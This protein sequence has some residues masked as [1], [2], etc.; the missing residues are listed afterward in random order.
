M[1]TLTVIALGIIIGLAA[2]LQKG[3]RS[4]ECLYHHRK[5]LLPISLIIICYGTFNFGANVFPLD[6]LFHLMQKQGAIRAF[7]DLE[8]NIDKNGTQF[9]ISGTAALPHTLPGTVIL[10][11]GESANR[12][13]MSAFTSMDCDTTP[14]ERSK[15]KDSQFYFFPHSYANFPNTIMA[16]TQA[17]TSV[18]Q[19]NHEP[20]S[21]AVDIMTLA[22][23][24]G[25]TTYWFSTQS[26]NSVSDSAITVIAKQADH[27]IWT[28][29]YDE[30]LLSLLESVPASQNNFIIL[31]LMGSHFRYDK[32]VSPSFAHEQG[33]T[34]LSKNH[35]K[36]WYRRSLF[37]TDT[38]L[39]KIYEY[40]TS[41]LNLQSMIYCS[42]HGEKE[43]LSK[44]CP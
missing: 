23:K 8:R 10:V 5:G 3:T 24:A 16:L 39:K 1:I 19:Y 13:E 35:K 29:G 28:R 22:K 4:T 30:G 15:S 40:G 44:F 33:W 31:H 38:L 21:H 26:Q 36:E 12:D 17:L 32:R 11:L 14:W 2:A 42:D 34:P 37:Y 6:Q 9:S 27:A 43:S 18:N 25:Y 20:I 7:V 41:Y